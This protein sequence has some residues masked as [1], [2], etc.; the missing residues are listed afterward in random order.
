[1]VCMHVLHRQTEV[2]CFSLVGFIV[3]LQMRLPCRCL[4]NSCCPYGGLC[5]VGCALP[6]TRICG[7]WAVCVVSFSVSL[8]SLCFVSLLLGSLFLMLGLSCFCFLML[9]LS[10]LRLWLWFVVCVCVVLFPLNTGR[11][12]EMLKN[13]LCYIKSGFSHTNK[14]HDT[15]K[16]KTYELPRQRYRNSPHHGCGR[17]C[18]FS[19]VSFQVF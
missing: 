1:M 8:L 10:C 14:P 13:S 17:G 18:G 5:N 16:R 2:V 6:G 4:S 15:Q 12:D 9:G 3:V 11:M 7:C 19:S